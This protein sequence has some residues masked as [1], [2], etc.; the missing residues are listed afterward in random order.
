MLEILEAGLQAAD[1]YNN[2]RRLVRR[3][4]HWLVVEGS[5]FEP[6]G[7][8]ASG[9]ATFDLDQVGRV[10]VVGACKGAYRVALALE[11]A[12]GDRLTGGQ[13]ICKHG[14]QADLRRVGVT[15]G[16][17]PVPDEG[18]LRGCQRI[19][20]LCHG[21]RE[22]DL[23]FTIAGNGISALLTLPV[24]GVSLEDVRRTTYLMQIERGAPTVDLNPI[25]NHLDQLKGGR[26]SRFLQP[27]TALHFVLRDP[28]DYDYYLHQ[29]IWLHFLPEGSTYADAVAM[30]RRW[31]AWEEVPASV[32]EHLLRADPAQETVKPAE[33]AQ[34]RFRLFGLSPN[35]LGPLPAAQAKAAELGYQPH[36]LCT[37]LRIE[38]SQAGLFVAGIA[39]ETE[40]QGVP[41]TPPCALFTS[42]ELLV[43]VGREDGV[44]GR[45][46]E[47]ALA[48]AR[49]IAGSASIV[50]GAVDTDGT[51]GPGRQFRA[52]GQAAPQLAGGLVDGQTA[53][54]AAARDVDLQA[55]LRRHDATPALWQLDSGIVATQNISVNDLGVALIGAPNTL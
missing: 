9:P 14:D 5:D 36:I 25:R 55:S 12:L 7:D 11:D 42:G 37:D 31:D 35:K 18:C 29:N 27:A 45:N 38:A 21:L 43:T 15:F 33:F 49:E 46:Q 54:L 13:I 30:L 53:A 39:K 32:R 2:T 51:D 19:L 24:P 10:F 40:R 1:P 20:D 47:Y 22:N 44:G 34:G 41:F 6:R 4:G 17:H 23:V 16:A 52:H 3:E 50:I 26:I 28:G 8:P 48:A